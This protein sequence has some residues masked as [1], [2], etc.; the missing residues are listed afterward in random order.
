MY[1]RKKST[2]TWETL[3]TT[4]SRLLMAFENNIC[5]MVR[6]G[7]GD[8]RIRFFIARALL[9]IEELIDDPDT[10]QGLIDQ[11]V[12]HVVLKSRVLAQAEMALELAHRIAVNRRSLVRP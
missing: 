4:V 2:Q 1:I 7:S 10:R 3:I 11:G 6:A 12:D 9:S 5:R 8:H